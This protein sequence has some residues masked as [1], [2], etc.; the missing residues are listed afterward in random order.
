[1]YSWFILGTKIYRADDI[2]SFG[3]NIKMCKSRANETDLPI[4]FFYKTHLVKPVKIQIVAEAQ[5]YSG[6]K[7][8]AFN[9]QGV[10]NVAIF[11]FGQGTSRVAIFHRGGIFVGSFTV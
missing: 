11:G 6:C 10:K 8:T 5:K 4:T 9:F 3:T 7:N 2:E 1:M